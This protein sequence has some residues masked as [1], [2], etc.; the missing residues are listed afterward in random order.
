M[1]IPDS[2]PAHLSRASQNSVPQAA[3]MPAC[4]AQVTRFTCPVAPL[5]KQFELRDGQVHKTSHAR[6]SRG[7]AETVA[8][9]T[10]G[11][12]NQLLEG[13][14]PRQ[15]I[16]TG[17]LRQG[18]TAQ[19]GPQAKLRPGEISRSLAHFH[20]P[21]RR[22][23][24]LLVDYDSKSMP[25]DVEDRIN[26]LGGPIEALFHLWPQARQAAY[27]IRPSSSDGV[28]RS[29][30]EGS[31]S[32]GFHVYILIPDL[33]LSRQILTDLQCRAWT[34]GLAW[35]ALSASGSVLIRSITDVAVASPERLI[36]EAA[37]IVL[38]PLV[39]R[40]TPTVVHE[41]IAVAPPLITDDERREAARRQNEAHKLIKPNAKKAEKVWTERQVEQEVER[42]G[43]T[44]EAAR[45]AV[46]QRLRRRLLDDDML[47]DLA[48]DR[49]VT[50]AMLLDDPQR[51]DRQPIPDPIEGRSYGLDKATLFLTPRP[52]HPDD[53]PCIVS[54][55]HGNRTVYRFARYALA[56]VSPRHPMP[57]TGK[58]RAPALASI[59]EMILQWGRD[60]DRWVRLMRERAAEDGGG[61]FNADGPVSGAQAEAAPKCLESG[62]LGTGKTAAGVGRSG[63]PG[64]LHEGHGYLTVMYS[65]DHEKSAEAY[66]DF[67]ANRPAGLVPHALQ[68]RGRSAP[69]PEGDG[70]MCQLAP[71]AEAAARQG[72]D[73]REV[74]CRQC[75]FAANCAYLE[76]LR[77]IPAAK[78]DTKG[79]VIFAVHDHAFTGLP[80][81]LRPDRAIF[82]E[83][84]RD[85]AKREHAVALDEW[86]RDL[87]F[88]VTWPGVSRDEAARHLH[89]LRTR[90][91]PLR[92]AVREAVIAHP[93][94]GLEHIARIARHVDPHATS[95]ATVLRQ[96][97]ETLRDM[98]DRR[99]GPNIAAVVATDAAATLDAGAVAASFDKI[100]KGDASRILTPFIGIF[101]AFAAELAQAHGPALR[102]VH[103]LRLSGIDCIV[104]ETL[105]RLAVPEDAP[106]L[107]LDGTADI[108]LARAWFGKD[109]QQHHISVERLG[110]A[111]FVSG[112][113]FSTL[114]LTGYNPVTKRPWYP[115]DAEKLRDR[116]RQV[117]ARHPGSFIAMSKPALMAF[118]QLPGHRKAHF[119]AL[120]GRNLA[121]DCTTG[122][123]IGRNLPPVQGLERLAR[124]FAVALDR[125]FTPLAPAPG[126]ATARYRRR[127]DGL[128]MRDGSGHA[129]ALDYHPDPTAEA[130]LRQIRDA[131]TT[132][133]VD[134]VR[135]QYQPKLI[136]VAGASM[137]DVTFDRVEEWSDFAD[138]GSALART[139]DRGVLPLSATE[140]VRVHGDLWRNTKAVQRDKRYQVFR[141]TVLTGQPIYMSN[142]VR[143]GRS[144]HP[145][146]VVRYTRP[147]AGTG[148]GQRARSFE[149]LV[150]ARRE[151]VAELID[152]RLGPVT[153]WQVEPLQPQ[154][155]ERPANTD[156]APKRRA[157]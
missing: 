65:I 74:M 77:D 152:A 143:H 51:Y 23:G 114:C 66:A 90:I 144:E 29:G 89:L 139:L 68:L 79:L 127:R 84:P 63:T 54:H 122:L 126:E 116:L 95:P 69:R 45:K 48:D 9:P 30:A 129:V 35:C 40:P 1:S 110:E 155:D 118:G 151:E 62:S 137:P 26:R 140:L 52:D 2:D 6:L 100:L 131:E 102:A 76:Q 103:R 108:E 33:A 86:D 132:Q 73:V 117:F 115:E 34:E 75:P 147:A 16:S 43:I 3:E 141:Q 38:P 39:R 32:S 12:L 67:E 105:A 145:A 150:L 15:A 72:L 18:D 81:G 53:E 119:G 99:P 83:R 71:Q 25:P 85:F 11:A 5:A 42:R 97:A 7:R 104:A 154:T 92:Q 60:S 112:H 46:G 153:W 82:D 107:H 157:A 59:R 149:A 135:A 44:R 20:F 136:I 98:R 121:E 58:D 10:A 41:G 4:E 125:P 27:V 93:A 47:L 17:L 13:L 138:G 19:I 88:A 124:A 148:R 22:A 111:I 56:P 113:Q 57:A 80:G 64:L 106:L 91:D 31:R 55:A 36:F 123:V 94:N 21:E 78:A 101:D 14:T 37:P 28:G 49:Q 156:R 130:L 128:R 24:W 146:C 134:R 70:Q 142:Y 8:A 50:A 120:R 109:L 133:A 96:A 61:A 87:A